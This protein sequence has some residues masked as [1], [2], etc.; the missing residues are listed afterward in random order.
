MKRVLWSVL[1][2]GTGYLALG[3]GPST[4][5]AGRASAACVLCPP[6][7]TSTTTKSTTTVPPPSTTTTTT[8]AP[9]PRPTK[10]DADFLP[11][12][13]AKSG[14]PCAVDPLQIA[15]AEPT[16]ASG[17]QFSAE[18]VWV[19]SPD[20]PVR[21]PAPASGSSPVVL[22]DRSAVKCSTSAQAP[23]G[24]TELC[25]DW[26]SGLTYTRGKE[27]WILDGSYR[28]EACSGSPCQVSNAYTPAQI[29]VAVAPRP[30]A[31]VHASSSQGVVQISWTP[32]AKAE[33]DLFGYAVTRD[34][35]QIYICTLQGAGF[36]GEPECPSS[37]STDD[38]PPTG[39]WTY[40]VTA[41]RFGADPALA[42][43]LA[44]PASA[45]PTSTPFYHLP[46]TATP[47]TSGYSNPI[48]IPDLGSTAPSATNPA[49]SGSGA[50][51]AP[52]LNGESAAGGA[53]GGDL[54]YNGQSTFN[55]PASEAI[56][57]REVGSSKPDPVPTAMIALAVI[58]LA[59][60]A[61]A[62]YLR[63]ELAVR[64]G[65]L[66]DGPGAG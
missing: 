34:G 6:S 43:L 56:G 53:G 11:C 24:D 33:P 55:D 12:A 60:A 3:L 61:H 51:D 47:D 30:P 16:K 4:G 14:G 42:D 63:A 50:S 29:G 66:R 38:Q 18:V 37:M 22:D 54:P 7:T 1:V 64:A 15:V 20:R 13:P 59:L 36:G 28:V 27:A 58:A 41:L 21:A 57:V 8:T 9:A 46:S 45:S 40:S 26:P 35:Q 10:L 49:P 19:S 17:G 31:R 62:V 5:A 52:A 25:W 32:A 48:V 2:V 23:S 39:T 44:S 65:R